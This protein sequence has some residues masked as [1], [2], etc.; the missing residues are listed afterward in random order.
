MNFAMFSVF[1]QTERNS[2]GLFCMAVRTINSEGDTSLRIVR[3]HESKCHGCQLFCSASLLGS[4]DPLF[5]GDS[6]QTRNT[7]Q[8]RT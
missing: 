5:C 4:T 8:H 3:S 6:T 7:N 1:E 2:T